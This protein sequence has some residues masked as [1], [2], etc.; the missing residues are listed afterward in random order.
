MPQRY[1]LLGTEHNS[2]RVMR[3][4]NS[5]RPLREY[6]ATLRHYAIYREFISGRGL[7]RFHNA[8]DER[9]LV[10]HRN[11]PYWVNRGR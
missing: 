8:T 3:K 4:S 5:L 6:G 2:V 1:C 11:D 9:Y 7:G 10:E